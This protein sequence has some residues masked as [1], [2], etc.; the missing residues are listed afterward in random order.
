MMI[1]FRSSALQ[2]ACTVVLLGV[3]A[4]ASAQLI[5]ESVSSISLPAAFDD[6]VQVGADVPH[7]SLGSKS[8]L[9]TASDATEVFF[10]KIAEKANQI[11]DKASL[12]ASSAGKAVAK[13]GDLVFNALGLIGVNYR[14]GGNLPASGLD[15]SGF[16]RYVIKDTF[17][18]L[19]PR[20]ADQ[21]SKVGEKVAKNALRPGDLVFF[22]TMRR[23][24]SHVGIYI[25]DNKFIHAPTT[26]KQVRVDS[27]KANYWMSR[28]NGARRISESEEALNNAAEIERLRKKIKY[29]GVHL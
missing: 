17:G 16:V 19:L 9:A 18:F 22:N 1:R 12:A 26:G 27:M 5:P 28:Y 20:R 11:V 8:D 3:S 4:S 23:T 13:A 10:G 2:I 6:E 15:C 25:G 14:Y 21:M 7:E 24:F 29:D